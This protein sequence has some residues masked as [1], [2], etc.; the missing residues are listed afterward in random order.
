MVQHI[1]KFV[2]IKTKII[3]V[4]PN[5]GLNE[6]EYYTSEEQ[7]GMFSL[8]EAQRARLLEYSVESG[9]TLHLLNSSPFPKAACFL[10][11]AQGD[12]R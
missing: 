6:E 12:P 8:H 5:M 1:G 9:S 10:K 3:A 4:H 7:K 11:C 2:S